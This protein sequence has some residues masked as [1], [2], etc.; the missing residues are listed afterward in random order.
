MQSWMAHLIQK[1]DIKMF[2]SLAI[3]SH[4]QGVGKNLLFE[5]LSAIIG[6][7]HATIIGQDELNSQ[8]NGWANRRIFVI[9]DEVSS[10]DKRQQSDKLK[11]LIT[12]TSIHI[13]VKYQPDREL[14]NLLNFVFLSNH[15]DALFV[16]DHDRRFFV[17]EIEAGR[18]PEA[19]SNAFVQWRNSGGLAALHHFL[20]HYPLGDFNPR[21]PAPMTAAKQQM[22]QDNRSDLESWLSD[23][24][25]SDVA[26][27]LGRELATANE[28]G[29][30]YAVETG[31]SIPSSKAVVGACKRHGIWARPSQ[32]RVAGNM[33]VRV[34]ALARID[35]WKSQLES[36][37][38]KEMTKAIEL[39]M[40]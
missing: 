33:K 11:G 37:W 23:L 21:A 3:W 26:T 2:V 12:G 35:Y 25:S 5:C 31:Q 19:H 39:E 38:A 34:L 14:P 13:N 16:N 40:P 30:K 32:V 7:I 20:L 9:G 17:W 29:R 24:L 4:S 1:P 10:S 27:V 6:T 18:L 36:E 8:F 28:L 22:A 15:H